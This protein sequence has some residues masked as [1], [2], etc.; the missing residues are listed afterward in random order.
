MT[1][2][3]V[4]Q[5]SDLANP[6]SYKYIEKADKMAAASVQLLRS[7]IPILEKPTGEIIQTVREYHEQLN[8]S[9][10]DNVTRPGTRLVMIFDSQLTPLVNVFE[11]FVEKMIPDEEGKR[12]I[13]DDQQL[14]QLSQILRALHIAGETRNRCVEKVKKQLTSTQSYTADQIKQLQASN[15]LL[16]RA[17]ETVNTLNQ[18][19]L[20]M[21][22]NLRETIQNPDLTTSLSSALMNATDSISTY[23][24]LNA[25]NFPEYLQVRLKPLVDFFG[26]RYSDLA[27]EIRT[28]EGSPIEKAKNILQLTS[29]FT[30][31]ALL[32]SL[33]DL[34]EAIQSCKSSLNTS[35]NNTTDAVMSQIHKT[36]QILNVK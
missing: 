17:T 7:Q 36:T 2:D 33:S 35:I 21:V 8:T 24:K 29:E 27:N 23:I 15:Q 34:Q 6:V 11:G 13:Q 3:G 20:G 5:V 18:T 30:L 10:G 25:E 16:S 31:P 28:A 22:G 26:Q 9:F 12:D 1:I 32:A 19:L 14:A 4:R